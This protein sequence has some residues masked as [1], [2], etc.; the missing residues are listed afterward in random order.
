[1][2]E[3]Q[4][5]AA[6]WRVR[7]APSPTGALHLGAVRTALF[8]WLMARKT[9]GQFILRIEDT[10]QGRHVEGS[11]K[12]IL[13]SLT[14]LGLLWDE[15]PEVGGPYG[16]YVQSERLPIYQEQGRILAASGAAYFCIC[17]PERLAA[18][19]K[20]QQEQGKPTGYDRYCLHHTEEV[21]AAMEKGQS[22]VLRLRMPE[23]RSSWDDLIL[24]ETSFDNNMVDDQVLLKSDGFPTYHLASVVDDHLMRI[25]HVIRSQEWTSSTPKQLALYA[26]LGWEPPFFAHTPNVLG[27]DRKKMSKRHGAKD[28]LE[29]RAQG[30]LPGA[31]LNAMALLGWASGT[32]QELF[33]RDELVAMFSIERVNR[34]PAIFDAKRLDSI[35]A[36]HL[37]QLPDGELSEALE[38]FLQGPSRTQILSLVPLLRE[39]IVRLAD[40]AGLVAPLLERPRWPLKEPFPPAKVLPGDAFGLLERTIQRIDAGDLENPVALREALS[41]WATTKG[42]KP[43]DIFRVLYLALLGTAAGLPIFDVMKYLGAE[44]VRFRLEQ[45]MRELSMLVDE[46]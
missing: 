28:I 15:G 16:P 5:A 40:A 8:A 30:Y 22:S 35:Q 24:G 36:A 1:M 39:R 46:L 14:W 41:E 4:Q 7:F 27:E 29:Y 26:A 25:T 12:Q 44:E 31:L 34:A 33:S 9:G 6:P 37:R 19:R 2:G 3:V 23:G 10:D 38:P 43:R 45:G 32:A 20:A 13:D 17:S 11:E 21:A 42:A 18:M